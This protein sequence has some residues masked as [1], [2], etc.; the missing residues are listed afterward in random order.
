MRDRGELFECLS[1]EPL[2]A[3]RQPASIL[4]GE[5]KPFGIEARTEISILFPKIIDCALLMPVEPARQYHHEKFDEHGDRRS[6]SDLRRGGDVDP[7]RMQLAS[8]RLKSDILRP[9]WM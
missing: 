6:V 5:A 7:G 4:I 3:F 2:A 1:P 9:Y 8:E